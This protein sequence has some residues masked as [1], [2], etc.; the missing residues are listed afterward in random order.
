[1][2]IGTKK[3]S[4]A[5]SEA[6]SEIGSEGCCGGCDHHEGRNFGRSI[7]MTFIGVFIVYLT[8]Y[9]GTLMRTEIKKYNY[10]GQADQMERLIS[11][12][13]TAKVTASNDIAMTTIGYSNI[14][15]DVGKA[16]AENKKVMDQVFADLKQMGIAE[17]DLQTN[18]SIYPEYDYTQKGSVLKGYRVNSQLTIKIRDLSK[19]SNVLGLA[20]K[21]GANQVS[22]LSFTIDDTENLKS[23]ARLKA[24]QDAKRKAAILS[25]QLGVTIGEVVSYNDYENSPAPIY[26]YAKGMGI[27]GGGADSGPAEVSGGTQDIVMNVT[28]TYKI[29]PNR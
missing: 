3:I 22:G 11:V 14:D 15:A 6:M 5:S 17:K 29:Y 10:V 26:S 19:I 18:Y 4:S 7:F 23:E 8:F 2:P 21:F 12:N 1:M 27:G 9:V 24:L 25:Q 16:Q 20:G 13:G 28:V